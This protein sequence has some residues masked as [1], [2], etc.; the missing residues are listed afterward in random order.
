MA[1]TDKDIQPSNGKSCSVPI[2][3]QK[4][5]GESCS[6]SVVIVREGQLCPNCQF[7]KLVR[8]PGNIIKCPVCG[9]GT[10]ARYT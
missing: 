8:E 5:A 9:Y 10:S 4:V 1:K 7:A 2:G 6:T 3:D